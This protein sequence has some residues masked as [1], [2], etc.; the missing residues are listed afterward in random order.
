MVK[1][2]KGIWPVAPTPFHDDGT[3]DLEG[4]KRV[5]DFMIDGKYADAFK[6]EV[7]PPNKHVLKSETM[8]FDNLYLF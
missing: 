7:G 1:M 2:Y 6:K 5:L 4:M 8:D 3:L